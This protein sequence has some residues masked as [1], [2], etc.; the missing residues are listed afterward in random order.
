MQKF[1]LLIITFLL[2]TVVAFAQ[3][4]VPNIG[5]GTTLSYTV[6]ATAA[7]QQIPLT[8]NIVSLNDPMKFKWTLPG[9]GTGAFIIPMKALESGTKMRL[10]EPAP[11]VNTEFKDDETIMFISKASFAEMVKNQSFTM[12]K[13]TFTIKPADKPFQLNGKDLDAFHLVSANGKTELWVLNKPD[14]PLM[15]KFTGNPGGL[16]FELTNLKE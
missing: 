9:I 6:D 15:V 11:D 13:I 2:S 7:G 10:R 3:N 4:N 12:N 1:N 14:F 16:D 5:V 8:L